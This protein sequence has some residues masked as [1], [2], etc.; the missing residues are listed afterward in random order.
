[1]RLWSEQQYCRGNIGMR[2][3]VWSA[4]E[5]AVMG[6]V[7]QMLRVLKVWIFGY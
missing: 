4:G 6:A 1:M 2:G 3:I 7:F 5:C